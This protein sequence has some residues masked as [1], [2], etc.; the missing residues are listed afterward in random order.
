ME[1]LVIFVLPIGAM[2]VFV[3]ICNLILIYLERSD[4][5]DAVQG[6]GSND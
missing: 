6:G 2:W 4:H 5:A 1:R 3:H